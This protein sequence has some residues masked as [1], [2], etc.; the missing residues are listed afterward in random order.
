MTDDDLLLRAELHAIESSRAA[1]GGIAA[2]TST[3]YSEAER[4]LVSSDFVKAATQFIDGDLDSRDVLEIGCGS[5]RFAQFLVDRASKLT[6]IDVCG[7]MIEQHRVVLGPAAS[8][9]VYHEGF[10]QDYSRVPSHDA[11]ICA[12]VFNH[13]KG[14][15]ALAFANAVFRSVACLFLF[16]LTNEQAETSTYTELRTEQELLR[17]FS[18]YQVERRRTYTHPLL[19]NRTQSFLKLVRT[20]TPS[21]RIHTEIRGGSLLL[22]GPQGVG[23]STVGAAIASQLGKY[24]ADTD[25]IIVALWHLKTGK[26]RSCRQIWADEGS[27]VFR[28]LEM[29]AVRK[30]ASLDDC[31]ISTG[32][33][34]L[35][36]SPNIEA[37]TSVRPWVY[38]APP[39]SMLFERVT[40]TGLPPRFADLPFE[41]ALARF[42]EEVSLVDTVC[43][44]RA[45][46]VLET[47]GCDVEGSAQRIVEWWQRERQR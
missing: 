3:R 45:D 25:Q 24:S 26:S 35:L 42:G 21:S 22:V 43:R 31:I 20:S 32:G 38:L 11:G 41:A 4:A 2:V 16:D 23:K 37:L 34:A 6:C 36:A 27:D 40:R 28:G 5:G 19:R 29:A 18:G 7:A 30:A 46:L 14:P 47:E 15:L 8:G 39:A 10:M 12:H 17:Y 44:P 33:G 9:V 13:Q 1:K